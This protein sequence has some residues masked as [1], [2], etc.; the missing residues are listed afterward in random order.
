MFTNSLTTKVDKVAGKGLS[1][2]DFTT[3]EKNKLTAIT[4]TNTGDQDLSGYATTIAL[5]SKANSSDVTNSLATKVDK[6]T[7]KGLSTNDFT[8]AEKNK[9]TAI[10]GIN[11]G[12][13]DL[14]T[15]AT[16]TA[17]D[18][19]V[20]KVTGK[21]L[22]SNDFTTA[23]KNKLTAITGSNTGDQ[24]LSPYATINS[25]NL[26]VDKVTGKGLSTNDFTTAEKN[27]LTAIT[28]TNTGDQD[29]SGYATLTELQGKANTSDVLTSLSTKVDKV[30]GK[31]L[32]T[33]DFTTAEKNKLTAITGTNTGD[34]DLSGYATLTELQGKANTSDVLTSLSTKVDKVTGKGLS[35]NDFTSSE[36]SKLAAILGTNTGDQDLSAYATLT[37][38]QTKASVSDVL[39]SLSTKVDKV[40]GKGLSTNDF[41]TAEKD[42][43]SLI[44]GTN[45]GDQ[46]LS[47]YATLTELQEK[48]STS[49]VLT[50]LSTKVDKITGK[51]LSTNDFT[52][53]EKDKLTLITGT[54]T[55]DQDLSF[56]ATKEELE[57][58]EDYID[59]NFAKLYEENFFT[60]NQEIDGE[61]TL[62]QINLYG[63]TNSYI[64][65]FPFYNDAL[66]VN[67]N[68]YIYLGSIG[69]D[70]FQGWGFDIEE[71]S[72]DLPNES[73][74]KTVS[75][76]TYYENGIHIDNIP[77][78]N[79]IINTT[80][81]DGDY[82]SDSRWRFTPS[83][84][85][86]F[87][88]D[89][90]MY[91]NYGNF[92]IENENGVSIN[93][94]Q[95]NYW[96]NIE[97]ESGFW[98]EPGDGIGI[99]LGN[100]DYEFSSGVSINHDFQNNQFFVEIYT[101]ED[102]NWI[103]DAEGQI[104]FP[105]G[106]TFGNNDEGEVGFITDENDDFFIKTTND[107]DY[108]ETNYW[109]FKS[110]GDLI[111]PNET[112]LGESEAGIGF[113]TNENNDFFI[114]T[115]NFNYDTE[116]LISYEWL[117][118]SNGILKLPEDGDIVDW[119]DHSVIPR[120]I[121]EE[122]F[123]T[124][125]GSNGYPFQVDLLSSGLDFVSQRDYKVNIFS[126]NGFDYFDVEIPLEYT[127]KNSE[128]IIVY[129][130]GKRVPKTNIFYNDG[131][132]D[133]GT[134]DTNFEY[135]DSN[136][137]ITIRTYQIGALYWLDEEYPALY[138]SIEYKY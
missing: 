71:N 47:A 125:E 16:I 77:N 12:D 44:T 25:L 68:E 73:R 3:A 101:D 61:L 52:T 134:H 46:D 56:L 6:I 11:T 137:S 129:F 115:S 105:D 43:L 127:P 116:E 15:Y 118:K 27:K 28:G 13:Q 35:S 102:N 70:N 111:L 69:E 114:N 18:L 58:S 97:Y 37:D 32:S 4:G 123:V 75:G 38:L 86:I 92:R 103:F 51:G 83:G 122:F 110:N 53:A 31:G 7:G 2:N 136:N 57:D 65:P 41:T 124:L 59:A 22:S 91:N 99:Y 80:E 17:L 30:T 126:I 67:N 135:N 63:E 29:L 39:T 112:K 131:N 42:K 109:Y 88:D 24:D 49:D 128:Q 64:G 119:Q 100:N 26:K 107:D 9:L 55:G 5:D 133:L 33:N 93:S 66:L 94:T 34:Q 14:S 8:T 130:R 95:V 138:F 76:E 54:N 85:L 104:T 120:F 81:P 40:T 19:K 89:T 79:F 10:T 132:P 106:T 36:K 96:T 108:Y 20:D 82:Y 117:F 72:I 1:T 78:S 84:E 87:P 90:K 21:G 50:S 121:S 62:S 45:T 98:S 48:A 74:I 23:E 60:A 113:T